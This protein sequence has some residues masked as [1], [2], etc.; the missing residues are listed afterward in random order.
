MNLSEEGLKK[1]EEWESRGYELP[2]FDRAAMIKATGENPVWVHFGAGNIFRAFHAEIAQRMLDKKETGRGIIVAEGYDYEIV[3]KQYRPHDN[4]SILVTLCADGN[5]K[6]TVIGSIA[7]SCILDSNDEEE[8]SRLKEV[9]TKESLQLCTF[10]ITEKGY[11]LMDAKGELLPAVLADFDAGPEKP[12]SY[13]GKVVSLLYARFRAGEKTIAM[14]STDNCSRNGEKLEKAVST[15]A[16]EWVKRGCVEAGFAAYVKDESKVSFPWSMIDKITP[17]PDASVEEMLEKDGLAECTPVFTAKKTC[18]APFVNA[19]ETEYLVIEDKFPNGRPKLEKG[20]VLF[21]DRATVQKIEQMKVQTCLNPLHTLLAVFGCLLG[22]TRISKEMQDEDLSKA[23]RILGY[24]EGLPV[25]VNPG[26]LDPKKF[27]DIV[28]N[29]RIPNPFMPDTPQRIATDT[30]QKLSVRYG[31][32]IRSYMAAQ[33]AGKGRENSLKVSSLK[34]IPLVEAGWIRYLTGIDD[35]G[36]PFELSPDPLMGELKPFVRGLKVGGDNDLSKIDPLLHNS[37]IF[38]VDL[39][40][41]GLADAVKEDLAKLLAGRG[42]VRKTL[43]EAV[44]EE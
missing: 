41:A 15:F 1:K 39:F 5:I 33:T 18:I 17:R 11:S 31:G 34:M 13:L 26:I 7:E 38:G 40:E 28:V 14:V 42:A 25:V 43:H 16:D 30:S 22:Y 23:V 20:G 19:E 2:K 8:Y 12:Q 27:I 4:L 24:K 29:V 21:T 3:E 6:K 44:S 37:R 10:T 36:R 32:T 35:S 9:F